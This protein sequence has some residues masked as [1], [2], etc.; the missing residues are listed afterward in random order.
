MVLLSQQ[1][2]KLRFFSP[3]NGNKAQ[4]VADQAGVELNGVDSSKGWLNGIRHISRGVWPGWKAAVNSEL[5]T[6]MG[7]GRERGVFSP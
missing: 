7:H 4:V 1:E 2:G 3:L 5:V 6:E